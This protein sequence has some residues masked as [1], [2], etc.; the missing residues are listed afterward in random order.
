[1]I[2]FDHV[3]KYCCWFTFTFCKE[4]PPSTTSPSASCERINTT[5]HADVHDLQDQ[6]ASSDES[7][8]QELEALID[9]MS[10]DDQPEVDAA[11]DNMG[12]NPDHTVLVPLTYIDTIMR[13]YA[14]LSLLCVLNV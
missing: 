14:F 6:P 2:L 10:E 9:N 8:Q 13:W 11:G 5:K 4:F 1:M 3:N 12:A 7:L